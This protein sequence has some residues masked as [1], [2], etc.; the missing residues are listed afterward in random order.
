MRHLPAGLLCRGFA[1]GFVVVSSAVFVFAAGQLNPLCLHLAP[2]AL[3]VV[4]VYSFTKRFTAFSH[5]VLGFAWG[6]PRRRRGSRCA[7]RS[8]R[9]SS[10]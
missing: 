1:W 10:G 3:A 2:L 8:T 4:F 9:G 7:A 6:L 5:L